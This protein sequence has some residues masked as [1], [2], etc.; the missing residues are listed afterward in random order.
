MSRLPEAIR[1]IPRET[2]RSARAVFGSGNF[3]LLVGDQLEF[4][5][6]DLQPEHLI[7]PGE[8]PLTG[9]PVFALVT[10]F[11]HL[12]ELSDMQALDALRTRLDWKYALHLAP[13]TRTF[14]P[15]S[16]CCYRRMLLCEPHSAGEFG[17]LVVRLQ[18][19]ARTD[20]GGR[21]PLAPFEII[22]GICRH[23]QLQR[24]YNATR[25]VIEALARV[26]PQWL[27][28]IALPHWYTLY[29]DGGARAVEFTLREAVA[30]DAIYL[31]Q[32]IRQSARP[33]VAG[34]VE[35]EA[36]NQLCRQQLGS[37]GPGDLRFL[38]TCWFCRAFSIPGGAKEGHPLQNQ[39]E[40]LDKEGSESPGMAPTSGG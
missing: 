28:Q 1:P 2:A 32:Q 33:E 15:D 16:L 18:K 35:V 8:L 34:L 19:L 22:L 38:P 14:D 4:L 17:R 37:S 6:A 3:Y 21:R 39:S 40:E 26:R 29:R 11:Q 30:S 5:L 27:S 23:T 12:E 10:Y 31:L 24:L 20:E 36:L 13:V 7:S 25:A 9:I